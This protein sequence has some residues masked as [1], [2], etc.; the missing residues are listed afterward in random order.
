MTPAMAT[1]TYP[2]NSF[3]PMTRPRWSARVMSSL[4][5]CVI[6]QVR[7]WLMPSSTVARTTQAQLVAK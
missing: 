4:A 6:D 1:P 2:E 5:V 7:P 3:N